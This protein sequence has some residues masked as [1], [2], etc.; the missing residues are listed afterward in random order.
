MC[1]WIACYVILL[2]TT[3][4]FASCIERIQPCCLSN[5]AQASGS[6]FRG[7][8]HAGVERA[9]A[10]P[11]EPCE[12]AGNPA[13]GPRAL[14]LRHPN[15]RWQLHSKR[16]GVATAITLLCSTHALLKNADDARAELGSLESV[17]HPSSPL[18][19]QGKRSVIYFTSLTA[20]TLPSI[21]A[22]LVELPGGSSHASR[23]E[24]SPKGIPS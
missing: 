13:N 6:R 21:T 11:R 14:L 16:E 2:V 1:S 7:V 12:L 10:P 9:E 20:H 4:N 17:Q 24:G 23:S 15:I 22:T 18:R 19:C 3:V 5:N 8:A